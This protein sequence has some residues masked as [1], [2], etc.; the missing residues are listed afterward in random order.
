MNNTNLKLYVDGNVIAY[1]SGTGASF[2]PAP[3]P[4]DVE[5]VSN[6]FGKLVVKNYYRTFEFNPTAY[7][8]M[9]EKLSGLKPGDKLRLNFLDETP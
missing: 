1:F 8:G 5:V 2:A 7:P 6:D 3:D 4:K 9:E